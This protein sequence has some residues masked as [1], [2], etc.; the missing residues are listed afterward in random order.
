MDGVGKASR[1]KRQ[2]QRVSSRAVAAHVDLARE[3]LE[4]RG[5]DYEPLGVDHIWTWPPSVGLD[6][7]DVTTIVTDVN[8][9]FDAFPASLDDDDPRALSL[10]DFE[11][12]RERLGEIEAWRIIIP[13][14]AAFGAAAV[15][16]PVHRVLLDRG[17]ID[18]R[19][20]DEPLW[21][22]PQSALR[23]EDEIATL[24]WLE[25]GGYSVRG[26]FV[27]DGFSAQRRDYVTLVDLV[28]DLN[29]IE[30]WRIED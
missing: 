30:A 14:G 11:A 24:V 13:P 21:A 12:L 8:A 17:W 4:S 27:T 6:G 23:I 5:W 28:A 29:E 3:L 19:D 1:A 10:A 2:R 25:S 22:W 7:W 9:G 16:D 18:L 15:Q 26:P 20:D